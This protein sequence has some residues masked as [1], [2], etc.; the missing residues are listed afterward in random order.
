MSNKV[1]S[2]N[3]N[4]VTAKIAQSILLKVLN[5][6]ITGEK[7]TKVLHDVAKSSICDLFNAAQRLANLLWNAR[8]KSEGGQF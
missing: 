7:F 2:A 8:A 3:C 1:G 6:R 4:R 5:S